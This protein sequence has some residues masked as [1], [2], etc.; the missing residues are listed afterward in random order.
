VYEA[1]FSLEDSPFVLTPDP[2]FLLRSKGHHD[3][4]SS[5]LYGI[6]SQKG[7]MA[8]IGD[9]GTGKT[10][11]CR[12]L[13][14]ELPPGVQS[15]LVLNPHLS[16]AELVGAVLD[17]LGLPRGGT[18]KGELMAAL[19]Q[20]LLAAGGEG[21]TVVVILDEAQ[22]MSV[23]A[24]EQI[25]ILSTLETP[26]RKLLQIVLAG[27]PELEERLAGRDLRQLDQRIAI[28]CHLEPLSRRDTA[29]YI[30]HRL[31]IAGLPGDLPFTRAAISRIYDY[32]RGIPR[33]INL[34]CDRAL[35]A[36]FGAR[37]REIGPGFVKAAIRSLE[38]EHRRRRAA[39]RPSAPRR[40]RR[41]ALVAAVGVLAVVGAAGAAVTLAPRGSW[42]WYPSALPMA[43]TRSP[44]QI[45]SQQIP[46]ARGVAPGSETGGG[47]EPEPPSPAAPAVGSA[48]A[49]RMT[50]AAIPTV[51]PEAPVAAGPAEPA[52]AADGMQRLLAQAF[53]LWGV[54]DGLSAE[55]IGAWPVTAEGALLIE[56]VAEQY[57][58]SVTF[59]PSTSLSEL[60]AI[61]LPALVELGENPRKRVYLLR[62]IEWPDIVLLAPGGEEVRLPA[63]DFRSS[64]THSAWIPW[65]NID[66]L[67]ADPTQFTTPSVVATVALRLHKLGYLEPPLPTAYG[68]RLDQAVR[69]FQR[70]SGLSE[71]GIVGP[72]T[73]L[74]LA[75]VVGGR[76]SP[77]IADPVGR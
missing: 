45:A 7:L 74:V 4:L 13:L 56:A 52:P 41:R 19:S 37:A 23:E 75:R 39:L 25:R 20:H 62:R 16:D 8:L 42:S 65:R 60:R 64:W 22:Q 66:L 76:F 6:T 31:R 18:T 34:V 40:A 50:A 67:P 44:E 58:L 48:G 73:T 46:L 27:Q 68:E 2:R 61:G 24:L 9:V 30:E 49:S 47:P 12:A 71:D 33:V 55:A 1:F 59:L 63:G 72:R 14:R 70:D 29:R 32:T 43:G 26:T 10:T 57:Q 53:R 15:A 28:R 54:T 21:R 36:A 11:L 5:L 38:G 77:S 69:S 35:M 3:I 51:A 17:D